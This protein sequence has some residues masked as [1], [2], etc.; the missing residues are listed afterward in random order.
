MSE[1]SH[2]NTVLQSPQLE[3]CCEAEA[4]QDPHRTS[5][6]SI[7]STDISPAS[8]PS[9]PPASGDEYDTTD[10][11]RSGPGL[12]GGICGAVAGPILVGLLTVL[13]LKWG[14]FDNHEHPSFLMHLDDESL[15]YNLKEPSNF[16]KNFSAYELHSSGG[17][18]VI[19]VG[20]LPTSSYYCGK[21]IQKT[22][23]RGDGNYP[24]EAQACS[25]FDTEICCSCENGA[26]EKKL[27]S[28]PQVHVKK[29]PGQVRLP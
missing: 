4:S 8:S 7:S 12:I 11:T 18:G 27:V 16:R 22:T 28:C 17:F 24:A 23:D 9:H 6:W 13:Y 26:N 1:P 2:E 15:A 25:K 10:S 21:H 14:G 3:L 19:C 5:S 29:N 20:V